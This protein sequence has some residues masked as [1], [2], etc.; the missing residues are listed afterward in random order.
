MS[1]KDRMTI[2]KENRRR[3]VEI[4]EGFGKFSMISTS[5]CSAKATYDRKLYYLHRRWRRV[6]CGRCLKKRDLVKK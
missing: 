5:L 1:R 4:H 3:K 2:H 6:N